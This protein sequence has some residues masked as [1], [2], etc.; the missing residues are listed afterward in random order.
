MA[1]FFLRSIFYHFRPF[2]RTYGTFSALGPV[3]RP[4]AS[5]NGCPSHLRSNNETGLPTLEKL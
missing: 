1:K 3:F 4:S 2:L 5:K